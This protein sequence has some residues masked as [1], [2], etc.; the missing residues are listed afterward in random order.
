V[1]VWGADDVETA[2]GEL[3]IA[4]GDLVTPLARERAAD[5]GVKIVATGPGPLRRP[6][7][8]RPEPRR[9]A[10]IRKAGPGG[11]AAAPP[12]PPSPPGQAISGALYRRGAPTRPVS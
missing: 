9:P 11:A 4:P 12:G 5:L 6:E 2:R 1:K 8:P 3:R 7:P 10:A